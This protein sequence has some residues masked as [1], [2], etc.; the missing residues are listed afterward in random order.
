MNNLLNF[1]SY[2]QFLNRNKAYTAIDVFGLSVS[3]MFVIL[4][5]VY[6]MQELSTDKFQEKGKRICVVGNESGPVTAVPVPYKL[7]ERYPEIEKVCPVIASQLA[8]SQVFY[9]DK[10]LKANL[11][12]ADSTFF[13]LFSF[14]LTEGNPEQ[15]LSDRYNVVVS[16]TFALKM[17]GQEEPVGKSIRIS[18]S[19]SVIVTGV[20]EDIRNSVIPYAD[21]L[22]RI[23]RVEEF[24]PGLSKTRADNAGS[25]VGFLLLHEGADLT[26]KKEDMMSFFK[27]HF[28]PYKIDAWKEITIT[29]FEDLY[30]SSFKWTPIRQGDRNFVLVLM[31]VGILILVFAVFNYINLTVAQAGQRAKEM[32]T[33]RLLGS[34][35]GELFM[36]LMLEATLLTV[37]SFSIGCLLA[38][39][40]VPYANELLNTKLYLQEACTPA[41]IGATIGFIL[42]IGFLAGLIPAFLISA[43]KPIDV[44]RGTFRRQ[45]KMIFSKCFITFQNTITIV[46]LSVALVMGLQ[47]YHMIVA[48]LGYNTQGILSME[49]QF[50]SANE[51]SMAVD[52]LLQLTSVK[53]IGFSNGTPFSG[54]NNLTGIYEG[55]SLSCQQLVLDSTAFRILGLLIKQDNQVASNDSWSWYLTEK[56]FKDMGLPEDAKAFHLKEGDPAPILGVIRD[57]QL[58]DISLD[59]PPL[60]LRFNEFNKPNDEPWDVLIEV[61]GNLFTAYDEIRKICEEITQVEFNGKYM[62]QQ[63]QDSFESQI[64]LVKIITV[65]SV[66]AILISLLGLLAMS[67]YFIQQRSQE[68]AVRKVFGSDNKGILVR[69]VSAF[70]VYVGIAFVIAAPVSWYI[71]R[72]WLSDYSYRIELSPLIFLAAGLFCLLISFIAVFYQ[73][74]EAANANPVQNVKSY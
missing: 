10:R 11:V 15:V 30:F 28:W 52:R 58:R 6:T 32:A 63:I 51:R 34:S 55:K 39:S 23:E 48:P 42:L 7:Q 24:N 59:N 50:R 61:D 60:M 9:G 2:F 41:V 29:P 20:M 33:R 64:R 68:V 49:N 19:T 62:D 3:L 21:I 13:D 35:R 4:I 14:K 57:F 56:A 18:D 27:E 5:A 72:Q 31:S 65:F 69:L 53:S 22:M 73:S 40:A 70:L 36:R 67:T 38:V 37:I 74:W 8:N 46:T 17:F 66:I 1:K 45:T 26:Q 71:M 12:A 54:G 47:I 44:V 43:S 16:E 25:T